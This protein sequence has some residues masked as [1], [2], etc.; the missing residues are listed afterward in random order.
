MPVGTGDALT[1][2]QL[3][4]VNDALGQ[5]RGFTNELEKV[6][7][8]ARGRVNDAK[9]SVDRWSWRVAIATSAISILAA[10]GQ[11]FMARFCLRTLRGLPA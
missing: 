3:N 6:V 2:E 7:A 11:V 8:N 5:A 10:V 1:T 4:S 9:V